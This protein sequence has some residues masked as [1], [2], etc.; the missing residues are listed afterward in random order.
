MSDVD[1]ATSARE[2]RD[3]IIPM[4]RKTLP[5]M[6]ANDIVGVQPITGPTGSI[7][8]MRSRYGTKSVHRSWSYD[9]WLDGCG[10]SDNAETVRIYI[11]GLLND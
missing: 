10:I 9:D 7:F 5:S 11:E 2:F 3:I 1:A 6:I 8:T 4:I